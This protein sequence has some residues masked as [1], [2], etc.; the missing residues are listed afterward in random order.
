MLEFSHQH[1]PMS[2][3]ESPFHSKV[4]TKTFYLA[5]PSIWQSMRLNAQ[6][7]I[8]MA[9]GVQYI[10]TT[11]CQP[12]QGLSHNCNGSSKKELNHIKLPKMAWGVQ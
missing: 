10:S 4:V 6:G 12:G 8:E 11:E 3:H 5:W 7:I 2:H 9:W 1:R